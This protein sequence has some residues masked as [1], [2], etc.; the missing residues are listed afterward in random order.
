MNEIR[1][2]SGGRA[3][4]IVN[5]INA[6]LDHFNSIQKLRELPEFAGLQ[7]VEV[8]SDELFQI[9]A[10]FITE[11]PT[12]KKDKLLMKDTCTQYVSDFKNLAYG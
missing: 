1:P 2:L 6:A 4:S 5:E 9:F 10:R 7:E 8:C 3:P 12:T 11:N